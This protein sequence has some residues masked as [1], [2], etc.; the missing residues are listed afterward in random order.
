MLLRLLDRYYRDDVHQA[1]VMRSRLDGAFG[2]GW[3]RA[4][5]SEGAIP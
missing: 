5:E 1:K 2:K 3:E 4:L